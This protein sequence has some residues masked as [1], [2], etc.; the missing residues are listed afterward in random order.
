MTSKGQVTIPAEVR[1]RLGITAGDK[2]TF[3]IE[4]EGKIELR[5][6]IYPTVASLRGAAGS[7]AT[8]LSWDEMRAIAREDQANAARPSTPTSDS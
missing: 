5:A 6:P 4:D 8:P 2:L 3:V 1:K 7:L